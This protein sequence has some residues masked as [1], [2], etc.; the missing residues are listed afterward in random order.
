LKRDLGGRVFDGSPAA[1]VI[2]DPG[3]ITLQTEDLRF[4][5]LKGVIEDHF[6]EFRAGGD[7][8]GKIVEPGAP[9][10]EE[11]NVL[12]TF[13]DIIPFKEMFRQGGHFWVEFRA[14]VPVGPQFLKKRLHFRVIGVVD[15]NKVVG[16]GVQGHDHELGR[17]FG[18]HPRKIT[19]DKIM[20][21]HGEPFQVML[22]MALI[23]VD[24]KGDLVDEFMFVLDGKDPAYSQRG[25]VVGESHFE[26]FGDV[27]RD[28]DASEEGSP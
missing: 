21:P 14:H 26:L 20:F 10:T 11:F 6:L 24:M 22:I 9:I 1:D 27:V 28:A 19:G 15:E 23:G 5:E 18:V 12:E 13:Q 25:P 7:L 17:G 4:I 16:V 3:D 8:H 2:R